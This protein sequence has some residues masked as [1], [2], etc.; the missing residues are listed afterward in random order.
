MSNRYSHFG[1]VFSRNPLTSERGIFG[2]LYSFTDNNILNIDEISTEIREKLTNK[3]IEVEESLKFVSE[4]VILFNEENNDLEIKLEKKAKIA[5]SVYPKV[6]IDL[7]DEGILNEKEVIKLIP[8]DMVKEWYSSSLKQNENASLIAKG[9]V[10][11]YGASSGIVLFD[12]EEVETALATK[13]KIIWVLDEVSTD[14]I[15][16]FSKVNG[17]IL[18]QSGA[19]S[20]AAVIAKGLGIPAILGCKELLNTKFHNEKITIDANTGNI[21]KGE[22]VLNLSSEDENLT[23]LIE[24]SKKNSKVII[25]ANADN[26]KE[27]KKAN[28]FGAEGI[29]LCRTEHMFTEGERADVIRAILF[30]SDHNEVLLN[31]LMEIQSNDYYDL[32][33][34]EQNKPVIVRYL[35]APLHEFIPK[36]KDAIKKLKE[37]TNLNED[38]IETR[39][40]QF[41]EENPML[42]FRGVRMLLKNPDIIKI[43]TR[44]IFHAISKLI[45]EGQSIPEVM[46]EVPLI[47]D[48]SE[49]L[50]FKRYVETE[51][52]LIKKENNI[53]DIKYKIGTMIETPRA[54]LKIEEIAKEVDFISFGTNDLTQMTFGISRDDTAGFMDFYIEKRLAKANPFISL[55][56]DAVGI[57]IKQTI[58]KAKE[59]NPSI[60]T[61]VCGEQAGDPESIQFLLTTD[62]DSLSCSAARVP[63]AIFSAAKFSLE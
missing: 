29:G 19:T 26:G 51:I 3:L 11:S 15:K 25:S 63:L 39:L 9:E 5:S 56:I 61:S 47:F 18:T 36:T 43:Q 24:I 42:G 33:K 52:E 58:A 1:S 32:F 14:N 54:C 2:S 59:I 49:V 12:H 10:V 60:K 17:L 6:L 27:A 21:Y 55:D 28:S 37:L 45:Q 38:E 41:E 48:A 31:K 40:K 20:H 35:D 57:L 4:L 50:M 62:V 23:K 53:E 13:E 46:L 34:E 44:A 30:T 22:L 16:L 7:H 8:L